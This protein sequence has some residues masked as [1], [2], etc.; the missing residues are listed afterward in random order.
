MEVDK[1]LFGRETD[2]NPKAGLGSRKRKEQKLIHG[3]NMLSL[4]GR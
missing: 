3:Q 2:L 4:S 1:R